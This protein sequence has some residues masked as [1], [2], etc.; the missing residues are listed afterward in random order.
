MTTSKIVT[1]S[2]KA[3]NAL[4]PAPVRKKENWEGRVQHTA[5]VLALIPILNIPASF[6]SGLI[7]LRHRDYVGVVLSVVGM[8][9]IEG[10]CAV[11]FKMA[12]HACDLCIVAK[13]GAQV[14][15]LAHNRA[16]ARTSNSLTAQRVKVPLVQNT[17]TQKLSAAK[18]LVQLAA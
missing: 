17:R 11:I 3:V 8:I 2:P 14:V 5:D 4:I 15:Q 12:C 18:T 9:P 13:M 6:V 10:E 1:I 7:S 16:D